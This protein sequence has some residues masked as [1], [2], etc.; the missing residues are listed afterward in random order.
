MTDTQSKCD[1]LPACIH[2][3]MLIVCVYTE[4]SRYSNLF[5]FCTPLIYES[6]F[7]GFELYA[8][9]TYYHFNV[10][11]KKMDLNSLNSG[12]P[13]YTFTFTYLL[14]GKGIDPI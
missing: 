6:G 1:M 10:G 14:G 8:S 13:G 9:S 4:I 2:V 5:N 11:N 7:F 12:L 3:Y